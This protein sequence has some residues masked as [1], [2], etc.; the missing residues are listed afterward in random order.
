MRNSVDKKL[1]FRCLAL[2]ALGAGLFLITRDSTRALLSG[3]HVR[4]K[5]PEVAVARQDDS[6]LRLLNTF[7]ESEPGIFRLRVM[8]QNQSA[9]RIRA[10]AIVASAEIYS[11]V[12]FA[13]M[14]SAENVFQPTQVKT[15]DFA[16]GED[17]APGLV[18]LSVD[19][20]E[21]DDGT[22]WGRD[23]HNSHDML[24]GQRAGAGDERRRLR[25]LLKSGG[26]AAVFDA[27]REDGGGRPTDEAAAGRS[28]KWLEGYRNGVAAIRYRL[29]QSVQAGDAAG[30]AKEL[31]KPFD[32][33]EVQPR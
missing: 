23:I 30:A 22:T 11:R 16:F 14:T 12:D 15:F 9:K 26:P 31:T 3:A 1:V 17:E 5:P 13:N 27:V 28:N 32:L 6:P 19:F 24:A 8:A 33:S 20:V 25:E 2:A 18:T 4:A 29:R 21:F 10:Y 7:V